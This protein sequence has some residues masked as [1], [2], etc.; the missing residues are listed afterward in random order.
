MNLMK[1]RLAGLILFGAVSSV[2]AQDV[3]PQ[4]GNSSGADE[5]IEEITVLGIRSS[6]RDAIGIKRSYVGTMEAISAEDFGKFP[7]GNLA[8]SLA[9]VPG[10]A[11]DRSNVE[12]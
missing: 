6:L 10:I 4:P 5:A 2:W 8:E 12:G 11:I 7:D 3:T 1:N 9:R